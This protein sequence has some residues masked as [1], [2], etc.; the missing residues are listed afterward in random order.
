M[1]ENSEHKAQPKVYQECNGFVLHLVLV[2]HLKIEATFVSAQQ[3]T[4]NTIVVLIGN[5]D[6]ED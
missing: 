1:L 5:V 4:H 3:V 6:A 2:G